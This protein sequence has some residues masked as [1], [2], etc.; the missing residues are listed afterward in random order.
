M[1]S[2]DLSQVWVDTI[3]IIEAAKEL[4]G[5]DLHVCFLWIEH[6]VILAGNLHELS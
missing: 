3:G 1:Y 6:Q 5:L 4:N 2:I